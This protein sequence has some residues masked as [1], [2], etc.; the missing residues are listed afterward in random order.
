MAGDGDVICLQEV[1]GD[2]YE[3]HVRP[4]F[5]GRG[6]EG[7]YKAKDREGMGMSGKVDGCATFW[8]RSK[9]SLVEA[10][11]VGFNE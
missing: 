7:V 4:W 9:M 8:R 6:Y 10:H 5:E 3:S 1:Q 11:A 2:Y